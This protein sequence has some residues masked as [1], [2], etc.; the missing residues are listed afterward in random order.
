MIQMKVHTEMAKTRDKLYIEQNISE[1]D[2][3]QAVDMLNLESTPKF[4]AMM[5]EH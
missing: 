3:E 1:I 2:I 5:R 4:A